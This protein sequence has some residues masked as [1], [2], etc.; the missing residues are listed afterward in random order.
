MSVR[1]LADRARYGKTYISELELGQKPPT[2]A[3]A[4]RLDDVL[5]TGGELARM[6]ART[7]AEESPPR[8]ADRA[9]PLGDRDIERLR[10][11]I[12][13]LVALDTLHGSEGL[14]G[15][16][17]RTFR[18]TR[19][20]L[21][22]AGVRP[23]QRDDLLVTLAELGEVAA[24]LAFDSEHQDASRRIA[25]EAVLLAQAAGDTSMVRFLMNH[26]SM[27][28]VYLGR[29]AEALDLAG[30]VLADDP[31]S[32]RVTGMMRVRRAR[33]LAQLGDPIDALRELKLAQ[34][35]FDKGV[36]PDDPS[37]T[38]WWHAAEFA[39][40]ETHIRRADG[41]VHGAV[42]TS[43]RAV[44]SLP[45]AQGRDQAVFRADLLCDLVEAHAWHD[46]DRVAQDLAR[47]AA[48]VGS[49][50]VHRTI[51]R[52]ERRGVRNRAPR[53]LLDAIQEAAAA[54][55]PAA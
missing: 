37:W 16:A 17:S 49:A 8:Q 31:H 25:T 23:H 44:L 36:G 26:L 18:G 10:D 55:D 29:P 20:R 1:A 28:A 32:P 51:Q 48:G 39:R 41:D 6:I 7:D 47:V 34:R 35:G 24:W 38:W 27:Q 21:G 40:H 50:R 9:E 4:R 42:A 3:V 33:A 54:A 19:D 11:T 2:E 45:T 30:R 53:W 14:A 15:S 22:V 13:H 43:E 5:D 52:A 12:R 46:A